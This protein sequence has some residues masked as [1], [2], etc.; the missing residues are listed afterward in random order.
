MSAKT[1]AF[2]WFLAGAASLVGGIISE[3]RLAIGPILAIVAGVL[4]VI[5]GVRA[6]RR[7]RPDNVPR[8]GASSHDR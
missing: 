6:L 3:P 8:A 2:L 1:T 5:L 7:R 4:F